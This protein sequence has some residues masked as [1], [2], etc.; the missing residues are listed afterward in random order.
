LSKPS[1]PA[2]SAGRACAA[3]TWIFS[4]SRIVLAYS[5]RFSRRTGAGPGE[6][7]SA[8]AAVC[9]AV[10]TQAT[11]ES[12]AAIGNDPAVGGG[13]S[14]SRTRCNTRPH[15]RKSLSSEPAANALASE[16]PPEGL[17]P[18]WQPAQCFFN[19]AWASLSP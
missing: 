11:N 6:I 9:K 16:N 19:I 18:L 2:P 8:Q 10:S 3:F 15:N 13:I 4:K 5:L 14:L 1:P 7:P 17:L 12:R